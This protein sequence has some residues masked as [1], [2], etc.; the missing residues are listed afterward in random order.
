MV[1]SAQLN[2]SK[3]ASLVYHDFFSY[4]LTESELD[5]WQMGKGVYEL[6]ILPKY[7]FKDKYF[8]V[9]GRKNIINVR[10]KRTRFSNQKLKI[11]QQSARLIGKIPGV[12]FVGITGSLAMHN[13][14]AKDDIDFLIITQK[15]ALWTS[16]LAVLAYLKLKGK[17]V[18]RF[19]QIEEKDKLCLNMWLSADDLKIKQSLFAAH[20]I[21]QII[22]LVN[23]N[24]V[25]EK[26][27]HQN[28]W[29]KKYWPNASRKKKVENRISYIEK[30]KYARQLIGVI[31]EPVCF[32]IQNIYMKRHKTR[33]EVT[34]IRAF[35]HPIDWDKKVVKKLASRGLM[36]K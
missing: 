13:A 9:S 34:R 18:R 12:L 32:W 30:Q 25:Y 23:K 27:M 6:K 17:A 15:N 2:R 19:N 28:S 3:L 10:K 31:V 26:F 4:P 8:F 5:Y 35:F 11:A 1:L 36:L 33:E 21:A 7:S 20:E 16:R 22:P 29:Y 14:K 24:K